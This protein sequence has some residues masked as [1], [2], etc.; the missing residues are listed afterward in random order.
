MQK[1]TLFDISVLNKYGVPV[2][3]TLALEFDV[4]VGKFTQNLLHG[5]P[6]VAFFTTINRSQLQARYF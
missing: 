2:L 6:T 4:K 3:T 1:Q 5:P